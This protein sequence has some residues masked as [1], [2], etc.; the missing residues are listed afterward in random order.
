M[1]WAIVFHVNG[2]HNATS[3]ICSEIT[4]L[5]VTCKTYVSII[6]LKH[7]V[8]PKLAKWNKYRSSSWDRILS[9]PLIHSQLL[10]NFALGLEK[11]VGY[12]CVW[13]ASDSTFT[14]TMKK[15]MPHKWTSKPYFW[16]LLM[17][18][19]SPYRALSYWI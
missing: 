2:W 15:I 19:A 10:Q 13:L 4:L 9:N 1:P 3:L 6:Y 18:Q 7:T 14:P 17:T 12:K 16:L 5:C 11:G 8:L